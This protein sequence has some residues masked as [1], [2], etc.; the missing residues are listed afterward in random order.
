MLTT[1]ANTEEADRIAGALVE[2]RLAACVNRLDGVLST[3]RWESSLHRDNEI[4]LLIKTIETRFEDLRLAIHRLSSYDVPEIIAVP[5]RKGS[6]DYLAW[7][8]DSVS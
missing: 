5:I 6:D 4:L 1:C 7:L 3:Y 2:R 8:E